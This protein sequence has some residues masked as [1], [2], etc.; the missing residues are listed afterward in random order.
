MTPPPR[1]DRPPRPAAPRLPIALAG[2][3]DLRV[4]TPVTAVLSWERSTAGSGLAQLYEGAKLA[5]WNAATDIDWSL[6]VPFGEPLPA[7]SAYALDS[8]RASP[9]GRRGPRA[10]D[11]FRW[12]TQAW[13]V[14]Q[15]LHGEQAAMLAGARLAEV[16]PDIEAKL[17]AVSQAGDEARHAE[18]FG[19]YV[20]EHVPEPYPVS[21]G[22]RR[23]FADALGATEWDLLALAVQCLVEPLA[24]AGFRLAEATFHDPL[25]KQITA[26]VARDEARHVSFGVLLLRDVVP[27]LSAAELARRE[28]FLLA[29]VELMRR[30]FLLGDLW[31]RFEVPAAEGTAFALA[32]PGLAG[33]RQMLFSRVVPMLARIGLLT[34]RVMRGLESM[35]LL[36]RLSADTV[37]RVRRQR[38]ALGAP[39]G[40]VHT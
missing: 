19:R 31:E 3:A 8:L 25:I 33:Y 38:A 35:D 16:L 37:A 7:G 22:L 12:Q 26:R 14:C 10:W 27:G 32:D 39:T 40:R 11:D 30:R 5:Q 6:D 36:S 9:I 13:T 29:S 4:D 20:G 1:D 23:L 24:L 2:L 15:F 21:E 18:A 17:C 34:P 28:D